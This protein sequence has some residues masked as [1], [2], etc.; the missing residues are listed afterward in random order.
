MPFDRSRKCVGAGAGADN[1][2]MTHIQNAVLLESQQNEPER[3]QQDGIYK[4]RQQDDWKR[5]VSSRLTKEVMAAITSHAEKIALDSQRDL[6]RDRLGWF[7]VHSERRQQ[8]RPRWK[9]DCENPEI[10]LDIHHRVPRELNGKFLLEPSPDFVSQEETRDR[11][12]QIEQPRINGKYPFSLVTHARLRLMNVHYR[13]KILRPLTASALLAVSLAACASLHGPFQKG[14]TAELNQDYETALS[15]YKVA[16]DKH[17]DNIDYRMKYEKTRIEAAFDHFEK[18]RRAFN[19]NDLA[20]AKKELTRSLEL[21]PTNDMATEELERI[22]AIELSDARHQPEPE[23]SVQEL[24]DDSRTD[25]SFQSQM[26]PTVHRCPS[27]SSIR[28]RRT[29]R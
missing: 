5:F 12:N 28:V 26:E 14:S 15:E 25:P 13:L 10:Y 4:Q 8:N 11:Q 1:G 19:N 3:Y 23:R 24:K 22:K 7:G 18:G 21:D 29:A 20:T 27:A 16:L 2:H 17:P 6:M 9:D